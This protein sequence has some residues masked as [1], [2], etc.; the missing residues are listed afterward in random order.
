MSHCICQNCGREFTSYNPTPKYC[1]RPCKY[2]GTAT[3][4]DANEIQR[5]YESGLTQDEIA[6]K[7]GTTQ[8]VIYKA[9]R[10]N[11]IP[12]RV[13]AKRDQRGERNHMWKGDG[14]SVSAFHIR[15]SR[16]T[17]RDRKVCEVCGTSDPAH[18]YDWANLT[19]HYEDQN[20]YKLM[21]RSCHR[22]YDAMRREG[23]DAK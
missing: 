3:P 4:V 10:R 19:G 6:L 14:A 12:A 9:M 21:C 11:G 1:C 13:A 7:L 16:T 22:R 17:K 15:L 18:W 23:G 2:E 8:K 5:L 20:D